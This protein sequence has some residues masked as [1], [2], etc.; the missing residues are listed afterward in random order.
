MILTLFDKQI[1]GQMGNIMV[2][3]HVSQDSPEKLNQ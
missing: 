1:Q 3:G 2:P